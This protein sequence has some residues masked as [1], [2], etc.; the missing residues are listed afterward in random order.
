M[1]KNKSAFGKSIFRSIKESLGRF[2]AIMAIIALG[3][4][5]FAGLKET[6]PAMVQTADIFLK[7]HHFYDY[8]LLSTIGFED[9]EIQS[10]LALD[11]VTEA[12]GAI[13]HDFIAENEEGSSFVVKAHSITDT[14]NTIRLD[15]GSMPQASDECVVDAYYFNSDMIGKT[16]TVSS[17]NLDEIQDSF[18]SKTYKVVGTVTS[19]YYLNRERG[20]TSLG[21]GQISGYVYMPLSGFEYEYYTEMYVLGNGNDAIYTDEYSDYLEVHQSQME[22]ALKAAVSPRYEEL[23]SDGNEQ[24]ADAKEELEEQKTDALLEIEDARAELDEGWEAFYQGLADYEEGKKELAENEKQLQDSIAQIAENEVKLQDAKTQLDSAAAGIASGQSQISAGETTLNNSYAALL[25]LDSQIT[26]MEDSL[27]QGKAALTTAGIDT[28]NLSGLASQLLA[29]HEQYVAAGDVVTAQVAAIEAQYQ[30]YYT[31]IK[32]LADIETALP[33][34]Q[35][36][37]QTGMAEYQNGV[38]TLANSKNTLNSARAAYQSG[39]KEYEDGLIQLEDAKAQVAEGQIQIQE[40]KDSLQEA[41]QTLEESENELQEGEDAYTQALQDYEQ[42]IAD[43]EEKIAKGE[44]KLADIPDLSTYVFTRKIN[45]G[46]ASLEND[47]MIVDGI[48]KVFPI[49]F[50]LIAA[51]VC[52]TTMT[53]M[54]EDERTQIGTLRAMG[55]TES[56]ILGKYII[57]SGAAALSGGIVGYI[58][59]THLFPYTIWKAY[60][61]LYGFA[62]ITYTTNIGVLLIALLAAL[63]CSVGTTFLACKNELRSTPADL[64]RP[65]APSAGK[66]ILMEKIPFLW[67]RMKFLHKV[68]ARNIFRFKKR[69]FM[70]ILGIGGCMALVITGFGIK[71][72]VSNLVNYQFGEIMKNDI[73]VTYTDEVTDVRLAEIDENIGEQIKGN[74]VLE[75]TSVE[76]I[77][78]DTVKT[79]Y[80]LISDQDN[81]GDYMDLHLDGESV[82]FPGQGEVAINEKLAQLLGAKV[83]SSI[84]LQNGDEKVVELKVSGIFENYVYNYAVISADTYETYFGE[85]YEPDTIYF[86]LNEGADEYETAAY[87]ADMDSIGNVSVTADIKD[88][89]GDMMSMLNYVVVL[90]IACAGALAFVVLFNLSNI[91]ITER[92]REIATLKV[93]GFYRSET[94][95]YIFRENMVLSIMGM[96]AGIPLGIALHSFVMSQIKIDMVTFETLILPRSYLF[97]LLTVFGFTILVDLLMRKKIDH[98]KMA[99]SLKSIE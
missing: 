69:M 98:I 30:A 55:Y 90:V 25:Y 52:S 49:F 57:Y 33:G 80:M 3:V 41:A 19:P 91:N 43:A 20:T 83:G 59:G 58:A 16:L 34:Y 40:A 35:N 85:T 68:S 95:S 14:I 63:L 44:E 1:R 61:L 8:R 29:G 4:G 66:R 37:Y 81:F 84:S 96:I 87:L 71:D 62:P 15:E 9:E 39:L 47:S 48:A 67:K 74:T 38:A 36:Q 13:S 31:N 86:I 18:S 78:D 23:V 26:G 5:F 11:F 64:I 7:E 99:E 77:S 79:V 46:Y 60:E 82:A 53:R 51:L 32:N 56:A 28:S 2:I 6:R 73:S 88:R 65:K 24:I 89:V 21:S 70:M 92:V 10:I 76:A 75:Q 12:E 54:V 22:E 27:T 93:L 72:S 17:L 94:G 97:S 50:F 42:G 45:N